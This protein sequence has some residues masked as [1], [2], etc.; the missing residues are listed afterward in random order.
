MMPGVTFKEIRDQIIDA[1]DE[2]ELEEVLRDWM[3][4]RLGVIIKKGAFGHVVFDLLEWSERQGREV[5]LVGV[6]SQA[7][8]AHAGMQQIS[9]KYGMAIPLFVQSG[10][11]AVPAAPESA[12]DSGLERIVRDQLKFLDFGVWRERMTRVERQVCRITL[13]GQAQGTGFLVG[14]DTVLTNYHVLKPVIDKAILPEKVGC[15]FDYKAL[16]NGTYLEGTV[17]GLHQDWDIDHSEYTPAEA[18]GK[19]DREAPAPDQLDYTLVRLVEAIGSRPAVPKPRPRADVPARGWVRVP[20]AAPAFA[21]K[22]PLLIAQHPE[23]SPL[24]LAIDTHAIDKDAGLW[25]NANQTRVRYATNTE[26]G[27]SGSPCFDQDWNLIALHHYGDPKYLQPRYNQGIP[28]GRIRERL[29]AQ[30]KAAA[31]GGDSK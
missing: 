22:M 7:R 14:P 20:D 19:P 31:L 18:D 21:A 29:T 23:G 27:S 9:K 26:G 4:I 16:A 10:G 8:P 17:V 28:I 3:N 11:A 25:L 15:Q 24:K 2:D 6:L 1:F 13:D 5:E 12:A 30:G